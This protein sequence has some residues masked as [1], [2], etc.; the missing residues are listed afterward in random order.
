MNRTDFMDSFRNVSQPQIVTFA[1][2]PTQDG[3]Y[4]PITLE[5]Y[6][7]TSI[8]PPMFAVSI[9]HQRYSYECFQEASAFNLV[10]PNKN[11][12]QETILFGSKSGADCNKLEL[13]KLEHFKGR[14]RQIPIIKNAAAVF[15]CEIVSQ[16]RSGDHTIY[17]GEVKY[18]WS[19]LDENPLLLQ[20]LKS[21]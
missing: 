9:G 6:M 4:N 3:R 13:S 21:R 20:D 10:F 5:W 18:S 16:V 11:Q 17:V 7:R 15:E 14:Y 2:V 12:V 8:N 19:N 1:I